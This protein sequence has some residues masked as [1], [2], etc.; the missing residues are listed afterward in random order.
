MHDIISLQ[1]NANLKY[2][3]IQ[4]IPMR[5]VSFFYKQEK[6][7]INFSTGKEIG[8]LTLYLWE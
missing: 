4:T 2:N 8:S 3:E 7:I 1:E 5:M 6:K